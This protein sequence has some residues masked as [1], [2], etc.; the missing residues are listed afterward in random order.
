MW[1]VNVLSARFEEQNSQWEKR[2]K[3]KE[4]EK[5]E[6]EDRLDKVKNTSA[7]LNTNIIVFVELEGI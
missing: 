3:Q 4:Q 6:V 2:I 5:S 7:H 1:P